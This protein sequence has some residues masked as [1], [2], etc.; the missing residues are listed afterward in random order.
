MAFTRRMGRTLLALAASTFLATSAYAVTESV[1]IAGEATSG[2]GLDIF[3]EDT[4]GPAAAI[5]EINVNVMPGYTEAQTRDSLFVASIAV[6]P[7][8]FKVGIGP[9]CVSYSGDIV[10]IQI[11]ETVDGQDYFLQPGPCPPGVS[12]AAPAAAPGTVATVAIAL[13]ALGAVLLRRRW[14]SA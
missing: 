10:D 8:S 14:L 7:P 11:E 3:I 13:G 2:G 1:I 12:H 4:K 9:N 6:L 5:Y